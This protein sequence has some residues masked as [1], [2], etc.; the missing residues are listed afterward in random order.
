MPYIEAVAHGVP[1][2][3]FASSIAGRFIVSDNIAHIYECKTTLSDGDES[4]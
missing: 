4:P 2:Y 3:C 1:P